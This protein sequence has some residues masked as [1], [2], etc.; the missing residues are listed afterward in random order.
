MLSSKIFP[1][2]LKHLKNS[3]TY[4]IP[5][6][7][8]LAT[9]PLPLP[10]TLVTRHWAPAI[11]AFFLI[12]FLILGCLLLFIP[13]PWFQMLFLQ[14]SHGLPYHIHLASGQVSLFQRRLPWSFKPVLLNWRW[15]C[16]SWDTGQCLDTILSQ[17]G[18]RGYATIIWW[19]AAKNAAKYPTMCM[20]AIHTT[21]T[22]LA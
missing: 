8:P 4:R 22:Y 18:R 2:K 1:D 10:T 21:K 19:V 9:S 14:V 16:P 20:I 5:V 15:S 3:V 6:A 13:L 17:L 7:W 12:F 11:P